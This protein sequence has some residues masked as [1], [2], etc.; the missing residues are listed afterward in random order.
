MWLVGTELTGF[1]IAFRLRR[2]CRLQLLKYKQHSV[3]K[4]ALEPL[5]LAFSVLIILMSDNVHA[6]GHNLRKSYVLLS[7]HRGG[8][9]AISSQAAGRSDDR[10]TSHLPNGIEACLQCFRNAF[11]FNDI[12]ISDV[13][14]IDP[15]HKA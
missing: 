14:F 8:C 7:G 6:N 15:L 12:G 2:R 11:G 1:G 13:K 5:K 3:Q 10:Y 4:L 9:K